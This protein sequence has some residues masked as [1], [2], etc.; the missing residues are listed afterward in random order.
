MNFY[1]PLCEGQLDERRF[2]SAGGGVGGCWECCGLLLVLLW[3]VTMAGN[4]VYG[5]IQRTERQSLHSA[6]QARMDVD[7]CG[8]ARVAV[9][10]GRVRAEQMSQWARGQWDYKGGCDADAD[11]DGNGCVG[12]G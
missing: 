7:I 1:R 6:C 9:A 5:W 4:A 12:A 8:W 10:E 2:V 3:Q 11:G